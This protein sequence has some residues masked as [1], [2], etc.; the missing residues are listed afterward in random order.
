MPTI[1]P[2]CNHDV[3]HLLHLFFDYK[4]VAECWESN[5]LQFD[6]QVV[7]WAPRWLIDKISNEAEGTIIK[8]V[9]VL[10]CIWF[11]RNRKVW[12]VNVSLLLLLWRSAL[13]K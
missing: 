5:G 3:E 8:I 4:F 13:N 7:D 9:E 11:A 6:M 2:L 10:W 1:C 12:E